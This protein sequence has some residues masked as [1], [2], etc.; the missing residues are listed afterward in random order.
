VNRVGKPL[1]RD[2][3]LETVVRPALVAAGLPDVTRTDDLRHGHTS[4]LID[5]GANV[6]A[7]AQ[8]MGTE[9]RS[10]V[11]SRGRRRPNEKAC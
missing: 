8:R 4:M 11:V 6:L 3:F 2:K 5:L 9:C 1:N 7:V 10:S